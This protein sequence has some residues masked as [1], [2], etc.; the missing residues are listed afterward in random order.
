MLLRSSK[1]YAD[2]HVKI[3]RD[4]SAAAIYAAA[5]YRYAEFASDNIIKQRAINLADKIMAE[6]TTTYR[7]DKNKTRPDSY[8]F[9]FVL[10]EATGDMGKGSELDT[11]IVYADFYFIEANIRKIKL[12]NNQ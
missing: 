2:S 10:A 4:T 3:P 5:L 7:T 11:S 1:G 12:E 9:G 8:D 6:L